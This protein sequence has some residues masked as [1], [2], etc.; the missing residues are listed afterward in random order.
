MIINKQRA[1]IVGAVLILSLVA[2]VFYANRQ[3]MVKNR[4]LLKQELEF[5]KRKLDLEL[6]RLIQKTNLVEDLQQQIEAL[7]NSAGREND[8]KNQLLNQLLESTIL[9]DADWSE[10]KKIFGQVHR[11]FFARLHQSYHDLTEGETRLMTLV[12]LNLSAKEIGNMLGIS[13]DSVNKSR[14]RLRKKLS[15]E[16]EVNLEEF[17]AKV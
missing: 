17:I 7:T 8:E 1:T 5:N 16:G 15:I 3:R 13:A 6:S 12:K 14:Y 2:V 9:T 4:E 10:F 11:G